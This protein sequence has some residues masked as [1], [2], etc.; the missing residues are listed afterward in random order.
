MEFDGFV[1]TEVIGSG[2]FG[3]VHLAN[4]VQHGR[5]VAIKV[6]NDA[7]DE[8]ATRRFDRERRAMG[9]L[10]GHPNIAVVHQSGL[11]GDG[12]L[13]LVME[14]LSGGSLAERIPS[15]GLP[16]GDVVEVGVALSSALSRAHELG[17]L[18]LDLKPEN[19]L[20]SEFGTAKLVDFGI[21]AFLNDQQMTTTVRA[22]PAYAAP[23]VLDGRPPTVATD[24]YGLAVT[25][26][27]MASGRAPY[28]SPDTGALSVIRSVALDPVPTLTAGEVPPR[29][30]SLLEAAMS[31]EPEGRPT[32]AE[33][34][35]QLSELSTQPIDVASTP[36][37][38]IPT[39]T[40]APAGEVAPAGASGPPTLP[41]V[42][43]GPVSGADDHSAPNRRNLFVALGA[44]AVAA[45]I[46][47]I[48]LSSGGDNGP[49]D[50]TELAQ[51]TAP[52]TTAVPETTTPGEAEV[53]TPT[54]A[55]S[56][57]ATLDDLATA[58]VQILLFDGDNVVCTGSGAI[59]DADGT[60]L[61]NSH[62]V[63]LAPPCGHDRI[64]IA[65]TGSPDAPAEVRYDASVIIDD[66]QLDLAVLRV[67]GPVD[68]PLATVEIGTAT[69]L[70][71]GDQ[72]RVLGYPAIGGSTVT[73][74]S[75]TI[76]GF[77]SP[78]TAAD[79]GWVKSDA[80][81]SGG[82]S[83][84]LAVDDDGLL[85]GIPTRVG[86]GDGPITDCRV[87]NDT[88]GDG[89]TDQRDAC[90]PVGGFINGIRPVDAAIDLI[91]DSIG[92]APL[93]RSVATPLAPSTVIVSD[94]F[95]S[96]DVVDFEPVGDA[97]ALPVGAPALCLNWSYENLALSAPFDVVWSVNGAVFADLGSTGTNQGD[98]SG[99]FFAC[100]RPAQ[101]LTEGI[102]EMSWLIN[103][104]LVFT[105]AF[106]VG[107]TQGVTIFVDNLTTSPM[108][109]IQL[110]PEGA[111]TFG[112]N[113]INSPLAG[114][115]APG[116]AY[117]I[118]VSAG[119]WRL[120]VVDC[121]GLLRYEASLPAFEDVTVEIP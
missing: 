47:I 22:T 94:T 54:P 119:N 33:F 43:T 38:G 110:G 31:K 58:T 60:I 111:S 45:L 68:P 62:V 11:T 52:Q 100:A 12:R 28:G 88:N 35:R 65:V 7:P 29:L 82:S 104:E 103:G 84:G 55:E 114:D 121:D 10:S 63:T 20:F 79:G 16:V 59:V 71:L 72:V 87:L 30:A 56:T 49:S 17:V 42:S 57:I 6:L 117:P 97:V 24:V 8:D 32:M 108:C 105:H 4:D 83:G 27:A 85:I 34:G 116:G 70:R 19:V 37:A 80:A 96:A 75:G 25:L 40:V 112:V 23:E 73:V 18:H 41:P 93:D 92:A 76:S 51:T 9:S 44:L 53:A 61:T 90:V 107:P 86:T 14:Y 99:R 120:R 113:R 109:V 74:T 115:G 21:A 48:V 26:Y 69:T 1:I 46:G 2:G 15:S 5:K 13:Y 36:M 3:S 91:A 102:Y 64:A 106:N 98:T 101:G 95:W 67:N 89:R 78:V 39:V 81:I 118:G 66:P 77:V 50:T